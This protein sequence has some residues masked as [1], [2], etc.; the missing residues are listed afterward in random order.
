MGWNFQGIGEKPLIGQPTSLQRILFSRRSSLD[1]TRRSTHRRMTMKRILAFAAAA[2]LTMGLPAAH[3]Q[4]GW[5]G[6]GYGY[7]QPYYGGGTP[8]SYAA[9]G[10]ADVVRSAGVYNLL[11]SEAY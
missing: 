5:G 4:W 9:Q 8:Q 2:I 6:G 11:T 7:G 10:Y 1:A 3:A